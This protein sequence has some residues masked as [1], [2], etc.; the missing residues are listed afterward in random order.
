MTETQQ[1]KKMDVSRWQEALL[2]QLE[3]LEQQVEKWRA[4]PTKTVRGPNF[5]HKVAV[6]YYLQAA[7]KLKQQQ[8]FEAAKYFRRAAMLGHPKAMS[9]LGQMF[10]QG[11]HLPHSPFH[12]YCW[13]TL[14]KLAGE[15]SAASALDKLTPQ[16]TAHEINAASRLA[17]DRFELIADASF[18]ML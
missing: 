9:Y 8:M 2:T 3:Q 17:A 1:P 7:E 13:L 4:A 5:W 12:A 10:L 14:A 6:H 18:Q 11:E 16:L 15:Q